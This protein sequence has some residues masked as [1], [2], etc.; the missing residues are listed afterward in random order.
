MK[1]PKYI[2]DKKAVVNIKNSDPYCFLWSI[3]AALHP[4]EQ[5]PNVTSSYPPF[6]E[7]LKYDDIEFHINLVDVKRFG[8][9]NG[10]R[11]NVYGEDREENKKKGDIVPFY[12]SK[13]KI[14]FTYNMVHLL[15][16]ENTEID[17]NDSDYTEDDKIKPIYHFAWIINLSRLV[18]S[19]MKKRSSTHFNMR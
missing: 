6:N 14:K 10:L 7:I 17:Q 18:K 15:M 12:I 2:Q 16:L 3:V 1:L 9:M 13:E 4:I 19:Q 8:K 11:I 5:N